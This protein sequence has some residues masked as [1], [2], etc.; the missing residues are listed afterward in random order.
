MRALVADW[1]IQQPAEALA[2]IQ[3]SSKTSCGGAAAGVRAG[4]GGGGGNM[5]LISSREGVD[6]P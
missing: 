1:R 6:D 5:V 3:C 2:V 4:G